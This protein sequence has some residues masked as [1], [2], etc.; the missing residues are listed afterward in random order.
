MTTELKELF[1]TSV[2]RVL[3][4]NRTRWG[5]GIAAIAIRL[6]PLSFSVSSFASVDEF[7]GAIADA[8]QYWCDKRFAEEVGKPAHPANRVWRITS[9]GIG[10]LDQWG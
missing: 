1:Q 8:L 9:D 3:D 4:A 10:H 5:Q 6:K 2:L 7:Y